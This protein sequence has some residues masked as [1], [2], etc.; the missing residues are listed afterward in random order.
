MALDGIDDILDEDNFIDNNKWESIVNAVI[1]S[2]SMALLDREKNGDSY[3]GFSREDYMNYKQSS[4]PHYR[5]I[6]RF[7]GD[8]STIK[9]LLPVDSKSS[10]QKFTTGKYSKDDVVF[11]LKNAAKYNNKESFT[12]LKVREYNDYRLH[13]DE[14]VPG[15]RFYSQTFGYG[16]KWKDFIHGMADYDYRKDVLRNE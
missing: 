5:V 12:S 3:T 7:L 11:H 2:Y 14:Y 4:D 10:R 13:S 8:W 16:T 15:W 6:E 1:Y 9:N